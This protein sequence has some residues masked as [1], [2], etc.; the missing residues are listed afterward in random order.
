M[1]NCKSKKEA[2]NRKQNKIR[3]KEP[4]LMNIN[5]GSKFNL[6]GKYYFEIVNNNK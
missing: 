1:G 2:T 6:I 3:E 5:H 4:Q